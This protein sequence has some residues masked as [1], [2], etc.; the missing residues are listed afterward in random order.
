[1]PAEGQ[2][3]TERGTGHSS[4]E[5]GAGALEGA[6]RGPRADAPPADGCPAPAESPGPLRSGVP[7]GPTKPRTQGHHSHQRTGGLLPAGAA[8]AAGD[9]QPQTTMSDTDRA[10]RARTHRW[11]QGSG[12]ECGQG[13]ASRG[14]RQDG[15]GPPGPPAS[16]P[17]VAG[18]GAR[19]LT[20][21]SGCGGRRTLL[22]GCVRG[23]SPRDA[24]RPEQRVVAPAGDPRRGPLACGAARGRGASSHFP[25]ATMSVPVHSPGVPVGFLLSP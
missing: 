7:A 4:H 5:T 3:H 11:K 15:R 21:S 20:G 2:A 25:G 1:M 16:P 24:C 18:R 6:G 14:G 13:V 19:T 22:P 10:A 8:G 23:G 9:A 17:A 12:R